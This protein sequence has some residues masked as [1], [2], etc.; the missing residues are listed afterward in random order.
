MSRLIV[1]SAKTKGVDNKN[2]L[3]LIHTGV[4]QEITGGNIYTNMLN[5]DDTGTR[6]TQGLNT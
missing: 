1:E 5:K 2:N 4:T 6:E 3:Y